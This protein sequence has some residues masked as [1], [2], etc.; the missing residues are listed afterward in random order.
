MMSRG[1]SRQSHQGSTTRRKARIIIV[2]VVVMSLFAA[3]TLLASSGAL[4]RVFSQKAEKK[5]TV[6]IANFNSNSPSKEYIYVGGRLVATEEGGSGCSLT[7]APTWM[8]VSTSST[9]VVLTWTVPTGAALF[10]VQRATTKSA[11]FTTIAPNLTPP[12]GGTMSYQ[13][14]ISFVDLNTDASNSN[15]IMTY[16]Y[17]IVAYGDSSYNCPQ[18]SKLNVATNIR[19][20][21]AIRGL[22]GPQTVI[23]AYHAT[24]LR[25]AVNS[26]WKAAEQTP[27]IITWTDPPSGSPQGLDGYSIK[28]VHVDQLRSKLDQALN[29]INSDLTAAGYTDPILT[30]SGTL[31]VKAIHFNQL[32]QRVNGLIPN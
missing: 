5:G 11:T 23:R 12:G 13:D 14:N 9:G 16:L 20:G 3:W 30:P 19:F 27:A 32:R 29:A 4:D 1:T 25:V 24:E 8:S 10:D 15:L 6:S 26:V 18:T 7:S 21:E 28:T 22:P 2:V 31:P 17:R